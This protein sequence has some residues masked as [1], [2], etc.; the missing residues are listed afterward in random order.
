MGIMATSPA[1]QVTHDCSGVS[2]Q[3]RG[4]KPYQAQGQM[5]WTLMAAVMRET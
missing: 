2:F 3:K 1:M 4:D 5:I